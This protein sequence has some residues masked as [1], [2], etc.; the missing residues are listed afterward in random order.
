MDFA[1]MP[2][3]MFYDQCLSGAKARGF[4]WVVSLIARESDVDN[5]YYNL[6]RSWGSLDSITEKYFLFMFAGKENLTEEDRWN[7]RIADRYARYVIRYNDYITII[8]K[9][10]EGEP[11]LSSRI[12]YDWRRDEDNLMKHVERT[13][14][15]AISSLKR[16]FHLKESDIPCLVFTS[17][18]AKNFYFVKINSSAND[19]Y[20]YFKGL[21]NDITPFL[22][23]LDEIEITI[24]KL[25]EKRDADQAEIES[26][27]LDKIERILYLYEELTHLA[28]INND[29]LLL[30]CVINRHYYKFKQPIR[31]KLSKYIDL[32]KDYETKNNKEFKIENFSEEHYKKINKKNDLEKEITSI[33][34]EIER[35]NKDY[36]KTIHRIDE[37][38]RSSVMSQ[39]KN[40]GAGIRIEKIENSQIISP[41][42]GSVVYNPTYNYLDINTLQKLIKD[43]KDQ[44]PQNISSEE[45]EVIN[46][47]LDS[48]ESEVEKTNPKRSILRFAKKILTGIKGTAEF[49]AAIAALINFIQPYL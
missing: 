6:K 20:K 2:I 1:P 25:N 41:D 36:E 44:I 40:N 19:I 9:C 14:T 18:Y 8:N 10:K 3:T 46:D 21:F 26:M 48:I 27:S 32:S 13:Q 31:G 11:V 43:I 42:N 5:L 47:S 17:L 33:G 49:G 22:D 16:Y 15:D 24:R 37:R 38:I 29:S 23:D 30:Q 7:S 45:K 12:C 34:I 35:L 4:N 39:A 28:K